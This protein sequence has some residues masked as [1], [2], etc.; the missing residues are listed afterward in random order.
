MRFSLDK[1]VVI[2]DLDGTLVDTSTGILNSVKD[3]VFHFGLSPLTESEL[4]TFM[5][6][7][8]YESFK[9]F[10]PET[11]SFAQVDYFRKIYAEVH[12]KEAQP[13]EGIYGL[14]KMLYE[15]GVTIGVATFK[16]ED[17]AKRLLSSYSFYKYIHCICGSDSDGML[18]K[19]DII[20]NCLQLL[21]VK[22]KSNVLFV[23]DAPNDAQS[24]MHV[25][26]A[27]L[28]VTYGY[29]FKPKEEVIAYPNVGCV[30][31][32]CEILNYIN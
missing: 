15:D 4:I 11:D 12:F 3:T 13:Y 23:G 32:P 20:N 31:S 30:E 17:L 16:R 1:N 27:F 2:F 8:I 22:D 7:S 9:R 24:A 26:V 14:F 28:G 21:N 25:G 29:G 6:G 18:K 19:E 5:G 10:Y